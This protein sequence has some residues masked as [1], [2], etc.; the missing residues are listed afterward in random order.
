MTPRRTQTKYDMYTQITSYS[1]YHSYVAYD[2][3]V[4]IQKTPDEIQSAWKHSNF[5]WEALADGTYTVP[6]ITRPDGYLSPIYDLTEYPLVSGFYCSYGIECSAYLNNKIYVFNPTI[7][8]GQACADY[9]CG[10]ITANNWP[11][12]IVFAMDDGNPH[13]LS[14][15]Q[16]TSDPPPNSYSNGIPS[17][18]AR[19]TSFDEVQLTHDGC[20]TH[21]VHTAYSYHPETDEWA[22]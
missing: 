10:S 9:H 16:F 8:H 4:D 11:K 20:T 19:N 22:V 15:S 1:V 13:Y 7:A 3:T 12:L 6:N 14:E 5:P 21:T 2:N 18:I 17:W